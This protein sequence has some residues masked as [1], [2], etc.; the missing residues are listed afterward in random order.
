MEDKRREDL[1][2]T[3]AESYAPRPTG[4]AFMAG[5]LGAGLLL[6][7]DAVA[8]GFYGWRL[9][10]HL[11]LLAFLMTGGFALGLVVYVRLV[12]INGRARRAERALIDQDEATAGPPA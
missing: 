8:S 6:A 1:A 10:D 5:A 4:G 12:R 2:A 3:R 9:G 7:A 11:V